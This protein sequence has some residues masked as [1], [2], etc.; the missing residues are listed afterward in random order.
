MTGCTVNDLRNSCKSS[1]YMKPA[2]FPQYLLGDMFPEVLLNT[3]RDYACL[4]VLFIQVKSM[5]STF[6]L[7]EKRSILVMVN[8]VC[9]LTVQLLLVNAPQRS[10]HGIHFLR[11]SL[12]SENHFI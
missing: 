4:P 3:L 12:L 8:I 11:R 2:S 10:H 7:Y 1:E 9:D 6:H 5:K